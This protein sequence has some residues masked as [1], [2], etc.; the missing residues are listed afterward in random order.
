MDR[1]N[2]VKTAGLGSLAVASGLS[3]PTLADVAMGPEAARAMGR[4]NFV[5]AAATVREG[6]D[7]ANL[8]QGDELFAANGTGSFN[9]AQ[10]QAHG[11]F[12]H[13]QVNPPPPFPILGQGTWK[14]KELLDW[15][16]E[17]TY[18]AHASG[19]LVLGIVLVPQ[20]GERVEGVLTVNCNLPPAGLFTGLP[21]SIIVELPGATF[22]PD[23]L[24]AATLFS[25]GVEQ[26]G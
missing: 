18:G 15:H 21:E 13:I 10:A 25:T 12:N 24:A 11:S 2:F 7:P 19:T 16:L 1:R 4:L 5:F 8:L 17:G 26:R 20:S 3:V 9:G 14:A 22:G 6:V 23:N